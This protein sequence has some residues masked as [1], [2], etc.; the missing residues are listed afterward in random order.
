MVIVSARAPWASMTETA[1]SNAPSARRTTPSSIL[2]RLSDL[3]AQMRYHFVDV[4][5][6]CIFVM[7]IEEID[8]MREQ[9]AVE[10]AFLHEHDMEA[11]RIGVDDA[12]PHAARGT[13]TAN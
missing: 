3:G 10:A 2:A 12:C 1:I 7:H 8:L 11:I 5:H 9:A 4:H 6:I 13:F